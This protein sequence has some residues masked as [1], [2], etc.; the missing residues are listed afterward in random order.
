MVMGGAGGRDG[1]A[2]AQWLSGQ[3]AERAGAG[4]ARGGGARAAAH[5]A[6]AGRRGRPWTR[7]VPGHGEQG[8]AAP[9]LFSQP[10]EDEAAAGH[11]A[12]RLR[13]L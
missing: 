6:P 4:R 11:R 12:A 2:R 10:Q 3:E 5:C 8:A 13:R 9:G 7:A 1:A